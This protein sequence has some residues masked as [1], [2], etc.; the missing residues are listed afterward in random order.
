MTLQVGR[1]FRIL[2]KESK[3]LEEHVTALW[4]AEEASTAFEMVMQDDPM[5]GSILHH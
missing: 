2:I 4:N 3:L 5:K 1:F